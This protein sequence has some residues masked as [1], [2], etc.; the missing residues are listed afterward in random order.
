[1]CAYTPLKSRLVALDIASCMYL[2]SEGIEAAIPYLQCLQNLNLSGINLKRIPRLFNNG[3]SKIETLNLSNCSITSGMNEIALLLV[4]QQQQQ[5]YQQRSSSH[6]G[7]AG[8]LRQLNLS[9]NNAISEEEWVILLTSL[10]DAII[11]NNN[12]NSTSTSTTRFNYY[13]HA[14]HKL[15]INV[16]Q[17][18]EFPRKF[19]EQQYLSKLSSHEDQQQ[20]QPMSPTGKVVPTL[21][22]VV[23]VQW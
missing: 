20:K 19:W 5:Q 15:V 1:M 17:C 16:K 23:S 21:S 6:L 10:E 8:N 9:Q 12:S 4:N 13:Y 14:Q 18:K 3:N 22:L 11:G 7:L 2:T